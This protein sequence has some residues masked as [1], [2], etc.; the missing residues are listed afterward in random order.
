MQAGVTQAALDLAAQVVQAQRRRCAVHHLQNLP[1]IGK[2]PDAIAAGP[3][4]AGAVHG[5]VA[6]LF[7]THAQLRDRRRPA[8]QVIQFNTSALLN[9]IIANPSLYGFVNVTSRACTTASS[10]NCTPSTLV[11]PNANLNYVFADGVHPDHRRRS[12]CSRRR[13][14]R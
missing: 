7:N 3:A 12:R 8:L 2:T 1:D 11:A 10:L 13:S 4:G 14:C 6:D 5:A 9:E